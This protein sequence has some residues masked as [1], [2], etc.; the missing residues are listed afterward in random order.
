MSIVQDTNGLGEG[1]RVLNATPAAGVANLP[2]VIFDNQ[3]HR[4][5]ETINDGNI[6]KSGVAEE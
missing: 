2:P 3:D 1:G 6:S 5:N 4:D